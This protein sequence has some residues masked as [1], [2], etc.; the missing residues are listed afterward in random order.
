VQLSPKKIAV[1]FHPSE[2]RTQLDGYIIDHLARFWREDGH[3][4]TYVFGTRKYVPADLLLLHVNLSVVPDEYIEFASQYPVALNTRVRDIRKSVTSKNLVHPGN[5]WTGPVVVKSDLNFGGAPERSLHRSWLQ[6]RSRAWRGT[7]KIAGQ[8]ARRQDF[9]KW[10][11]YLLFERLEDM[12]QEWF[13]RSDVVVERFLPELEDGL[14]HLRIYQF[15]GDR[16]T[17]T[18]LASPQPLF[19]ANMSVAA[20][21]IEPHPEVLAWREELGLDYGKLDYLVHDGQTVLI[22]VN[23]TT[24]ASRHLDDDKLRAMRRHQAEGLYAYLS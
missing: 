12:P 24:G 6:R 22:D 21:E 14:Y 10:T 8:L 5:D 3:D 4:V 16:W 11:D 7:R 13:H 17:C 2:S 9:V 20:E 23:K 19:K 1:L 15:L 18:R